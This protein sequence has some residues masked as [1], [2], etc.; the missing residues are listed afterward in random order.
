MSSGTTA[1]GKKT[2]P[3]STVAAIR[4]MPASV[5]SD[6][7]ARRARAPGGTL[8]G[9]TGTTN[10]NADA[11]FSGFDASLAVGVWVG[12]DDR[13]PIGPKETG[14][15]AALPIWVEFVQ[16]VPAGGMRIEAV[17]VR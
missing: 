5:V 3:S 9:K 4:G 2:S 14:A 13:R 8:Y 12:R 16:A 1:A 7:T 17:N 10:G 11:M 15:R 6:G